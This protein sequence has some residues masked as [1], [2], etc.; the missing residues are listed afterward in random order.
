MIGEERPHCRP[1]PQSKYNENNCCSLG[2][3]WGSVD[4]KLLTGDIK[5]KGDSD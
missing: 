3:E 5:D 2:A 4:G 1:R